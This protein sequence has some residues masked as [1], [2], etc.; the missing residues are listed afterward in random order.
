MYLKKS[1]VNRRLELANILSRITYYKKC[2]IHQHI[3]TN[4]VPRYKY[5]KNKG[6]LMLQKNPLSS[7]F[8]LQVL[9]GD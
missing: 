9:I 7:K 5:K 2:I 6:F 4:L 8:K 1:F 3:T